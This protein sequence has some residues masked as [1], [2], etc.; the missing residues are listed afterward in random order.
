MQERYDVSLNV[1]VAAAIYGYGFRT[2]SNMLEKHFP[3]S[4]IGPSF[5]ERDLAILHR[6]GALIDLVSLGVLELEYPFVIDPNT[7]L[8]SEL[9]HYAIQ[10]GHIIAEI[11]AGTGAFGLLLHQL[12]PKNNL[13]LYDVDGAYLKFIRQQLPVAEAVGPEERVELIQGSKRATRLPASVDKVIVR[14]SF[15]HFDKPEEMLRSIREV[16]KPRGRLYLLEDFADPA[17]TDP[18]CPYLLS[19]DEM[20][21][22]LSAGGFQV[23]CTVDLGNRYLL[24]CTRK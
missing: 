3:S 6:N 9:A 18:S 15:H 13:Y 16:M 24:E 14:N 11:G 19:V 12:Y 21:E 2:I 1:T 10:L 8:F 4:V 22:Y 23:G 7:E 17:E 20:V 5:T